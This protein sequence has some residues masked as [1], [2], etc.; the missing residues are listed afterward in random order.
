MPTKIITVIDVIIT[1]TREAKEVAATTSDKEEIATVVAINASHITWRKHIVAL[2]P[3]PRDSV[4]VA[5]SLQAASTLVL[6]LP[7]AQMR[8]RSVITILQ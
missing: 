4:I 8:A 7:L 5:V 1:M 6:V 2:A 3:D